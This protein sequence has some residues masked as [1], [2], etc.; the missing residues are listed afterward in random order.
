VLSGLLYPG[1]KWTPDSLLE[2]IGRFSEIGVSESA[3]SIEGKT[4]AEWCDN[5][6]RFGADVL[7]KIK[8]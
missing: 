4:R 5:A 7:S 6:E 2:K 3:V 1:E 8:R